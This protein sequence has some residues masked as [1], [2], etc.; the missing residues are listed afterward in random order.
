MLS[1]TVV[2]MEEVMTGGAVGEVTLRGRGGICLRVSVLVG[3]G[4]TVARKRRLL[5]LW[6]RRCVR[7]QRQEH[8]E[9]ENDYVLP[10]VHVST[11]NRK[12]K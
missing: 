12:T 6:F 11:E 1:S 5:S 3:V 4:E 7:F 9:E 10:E 2:V 8:E